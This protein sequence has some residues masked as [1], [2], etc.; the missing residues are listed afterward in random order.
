MQTQNVA[1][2]IKETN[3]IKIKIKFKTYLGIKNSNIYFQKQRIHFYILSQNLLL[4][5]WKKPL[6]IPENFLFTQTEG[7]RLLVL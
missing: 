6:K 4:L 3:F 2:S 5:L 7:N 1:V